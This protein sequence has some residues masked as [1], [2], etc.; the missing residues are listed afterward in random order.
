MLCCCFFWGGVGKVTFY[1]E[2]TI[3][4][5]KHNALFS[6]PLSTHCMTANIFPPPSNPYLLLHIYLCDFWL[7]VVSD[8]SNWFQAGESG[9]NST[10]YQGACSVLIIV[11]H[12]HNKWL[13]NVFCMMSVLLLYCGAYRWL[14]TVRRSSCWIHLYGSHSTGLAILIPTMAT[15]S[16]AVL[17]IT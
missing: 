17:K 7:I 11:L 12:L 1:P 8:Q 6:L 14:H 10:I 9:S 2:L 13:S 15:S 5:S 4:P 3:A 16:A